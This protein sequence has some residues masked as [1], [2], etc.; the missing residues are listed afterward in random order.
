L[1]LLG[2]RTGVFYPHSSKENERLLILRRFFPF[3]VV[4]RLCFIGVE[5]Y[6]QMPISLHLL[7]SGGDVNSNQTHEKFNEF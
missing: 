7:V 2:L 3:S 6:L 1:I 4:A 5:K